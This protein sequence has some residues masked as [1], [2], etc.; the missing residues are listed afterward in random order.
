MDK[1]V[2]NEMIYDERISLLAIARNRYLILVIVLLNLFLLVYY[3]RIKIS[4]ARYLTP[5][6]RILGPPL[7]QR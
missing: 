1:S 2:V 6:H 5:V 7:S 3:V 4:V